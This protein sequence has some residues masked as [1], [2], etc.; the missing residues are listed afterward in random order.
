MSGRLAEVR[1]QSLPRRRR[2][3]G[4]CPCGDLSL[5]G[6]IDRLGE[7]P[8]RFLGRVE[9][10]GVFRGDEIQPPLS[11]P[12]QREYILQLRI[13]RAGL[14]RDRHRTEQVHERRGRAVH[15]GVRP[16][17][18]RLNACLD[19]G[20]S[21]TGRRDFRSARLEGRCS[22]DRTAWS[23]GRSNTRHGLQVT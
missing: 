2:Y 9:S 12:V 4:Q 5:P 10:H 19:L 13:G 20:L 11:L 15:Q 6:V 17:L 18:N 3:R 7:D 1:I 16:L 23:L 14:P 22:T 21:C 8:R